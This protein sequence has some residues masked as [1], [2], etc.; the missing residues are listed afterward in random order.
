MKFACWLLPLA[1][2]FRALAA[3]TETNRW[4]APQR[5]ETAHLRATHEARERFARERMTLPNLGVYEDFR[6]VMHIHAEDSDHT[7]GTRAEVLAGAKRAGVQVVM[8]TDHR[9]PRPETWRGLR[10]GVLFFA[11]SEDGEG[12]LRFPEFDG[13]GG[14]L[15][16]GALRFLSHIEERYETNS[17]GFTGLEICNRHTDAKLDPSVYLY[18]MAAEKIPAAWNQL[19]ENFKAYPD[20]VFAAGADYRE[21]IFAKWDRDTQKH[22]LTGIGANDAHQNQIYK[23]T[24][25]DPYEISF[26]NL[27]THIL[28]RALT[29]TA[30]RAALRDG[31]AYVSHDWLC[32]PTGFAFGAG[33][34][35][36]V[37]TMGDTVPW[38]GS[39]KIAAV[40]PLPAHLKLIHNGAVARELTGTNLTGA[41][42]TGTHLTGTTWTDG[43]RIC[44]VGSIGECK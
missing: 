11:G 38:I 31:H 25:F 12:V 42:L 23:G 9:G 17:D 32:D 41:N 6:G 20:E 4:T 21:G 18:L 39:T 1:L 14:A 30:I 24:T 27:C 28:A 26:R 44:G 2:G 5:L 10:E 7:K 33:N 13:E 36:G 43:K 37:F 15:T 8:F 16:N 29:E 3:D 34:N 19:V 22:P 40:T 35:L